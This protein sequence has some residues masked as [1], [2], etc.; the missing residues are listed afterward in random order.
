M[1][2]VDFSST[3]DRDDLVFVENEHGQYIHT[4]EVDKCE[5]YAKD[6]LEKLQAENEELKRKLDLAVE[7][8]NFTVK[9]SGTSTNYNKKCEEALKEIGEER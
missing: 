1:S 3:L 9:E 4:D 6:I 7:A 8:L 2:L 5:A